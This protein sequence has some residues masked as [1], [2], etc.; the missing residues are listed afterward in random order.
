VPILSEP[1]R[2]KVA[3]IALDVAAVCFEVIAVICLR[4][5]ILNEVKDP[6]ISLLPVLSCNARP[7][8][9]HNANCLQ[10]ISKKH[11]QNPLSSLKP[12]QTPQNKPHLDCKTVSLNQL[13]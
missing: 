1:Y 9:S 4:V 3:I 8:K 13:N 11:Q 7:P 10:M 6:C 12:P 2:A 5:V